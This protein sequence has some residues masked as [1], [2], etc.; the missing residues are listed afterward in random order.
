MRELVCIYL[1]I[2]STR[3][4]QHDLLRRSQSSYYIIINFN[5][6]LT[7]SQRCTIHSFYI[8]SSN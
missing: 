7:Q 6:V 4:V 8:C 5:L 1:A 2:I 3:K